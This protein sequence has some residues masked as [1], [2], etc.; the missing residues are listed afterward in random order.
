[1]DQ[2]LNDPP[3]GNGQ[4]NGRGFTNK[5]PRTEADS[6]QY[7]VSLNQSTDYGIGPSH[8][9]D[10]NNLAQI[11][12]FNQ[13]ESSPEDRKPAKGGK[14][15]LPRGSACLLCRKRKLVGD[16][17]ASFHAVPRATDEHV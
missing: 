8:L 11:G 13:R 10:T 14:T 17:L 9:P 4:A 15:S 1:M 5:R 16:H 2:H 6:S 12:Q 3:V 7:F